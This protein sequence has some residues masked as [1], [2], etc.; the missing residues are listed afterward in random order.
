M[1]L[2]NNNL[3]TLTTLTKFFVSL[4]FIFSGLIKL[5]DPLGFSYKLEEYFEVFHISFLNPIAVSIA[6]FICTLEV[7]LGIFLLLKYYTQ[8]V[9]W[10]LLLLIIF[11][12]FL[13]FYSAYFNVVKTCGCFGDA[14]SLSPWQSFAKD[15]ILLLAIALLF[16]Q[17]KQLPRKNPKL[18]IATLTVSLTLLFGLYTYNFLPIIDFL[19]YKIGADLMQLTKL[20]LNA[21]PDE[22]EIYYIL[23]NIKTQQTKKITDKEYLQSKIY[24]NKNWILQATTPP[25]LIKQGDQVVIK[26]LNLYDFGGVNYTSEIIENPYYTLV[27]VAYN[28]SETNLKAVG[29]LNAL[30]INAMQDFNIRAILLTTNSATEATPFS[31]T[32]KLIFD[33]FYADAVPLKSMIRSNPGLLL[34]K[35]GVIINKW[36]ALN[37]P[38]TND[39]NKKYFSNN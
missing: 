22:Y 16:Y 15:A 11:F 32:N 23:K 2:K 14:I 6:L 39:L 37:L 20:P 36:P 4:L 19:P 24:E 29:K 25:K 31:K 38:T 1:M 3:K 12:S 17:R 8:K 35:N 28:L 26:D 18:I 30:A 21:K 5:N 27:A 7:V 9:L 10:A 34:L 33:I 13:T